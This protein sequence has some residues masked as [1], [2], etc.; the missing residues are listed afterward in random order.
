VVSDKEIM[1]HIVLRMDDPKNERMLA[2]LAACAD[3]AADIHTQEQALQVLLKV[4]GTTGTPKEYLEQPERALEI[5]QNTIRQDF[6]SHVGPSFR[7]KAL[8]LGYMVRKL[9]SIHL[10]YQDYDNTRHLV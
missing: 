5:L 10:G 1:S 8:Y 3:E 7:R 9:M 4:L 6:L 2:E